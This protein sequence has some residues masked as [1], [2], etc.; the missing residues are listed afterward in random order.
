MSDRL[1]DMEEYFFHFFQRKVTY[2]RDDIEVTATIAQ[3]IIDDP[4]FE[5]GG[6]ICSD[7]NYN[8]YRYDANV[9]FFHKN[10]SWLELET[11][12][13]TNLLNFTNTKIML[14]S[15]LYKIR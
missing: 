13:P 8:R 7:P 14:I 2:M 15:D 12:D 3:S 5:K 10:G 11:R 6:S 1:S 9:W 4:S